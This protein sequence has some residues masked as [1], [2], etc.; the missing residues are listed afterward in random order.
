MVTN[1]RVYYTTRAAAGASAP[2]IPHALALGR[3]VHAQLGRVALRDREVV[4]GYA[5]IARSE[6][7]EAIQLSISRR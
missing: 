6:S 4:S 3:K 5:V 7:D 2:G 1:A